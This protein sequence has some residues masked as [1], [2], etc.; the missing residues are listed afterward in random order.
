VTSETGEE[1][2]S[3]RS[4]RRRERTRLRIVEAAERLMRERGVDGVTVQDITEEADVGHGT[5]YLHFKNK[6]EVLRPVIDQL[7]DRIHERV[8]RATKGTTDPAVRLAAGVRIALRA[9]AGDPL[10]N[11]YVFQSGTPFRRLAEGMG[12]PPVDDVNLGVAKGRF[13]VTHLRA[14]WSFIDGA[15]IGVLTAWNQ[16]A[17]GEGAAE[18]AAELVL[19]TLGVPPSEASRIAHEP[20]ELP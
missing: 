13:E 14:T 18:T 17:V 3:T 20:M 2:Q 5:F 4:Q 10:W 1:P 6:A 15:L 11:W 16:G 9:I 19:R 8:D 12:A 7:G